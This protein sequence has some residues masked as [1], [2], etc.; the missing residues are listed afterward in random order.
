MTTMPTTD[1]VTV[2]VTFYAG[3][4]AA[5]GTASEQVEL[6]AGATAGDLTALLGERHGAELARVLTASTLLV[7]ET[8]ADPGLV[9]ADGGHVDV[10][11]PFA[12]G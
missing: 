12:G 8:A 6:P 10:L 5:A 7:E 11:P 9:L 3:A 4:M 2:T 1:H